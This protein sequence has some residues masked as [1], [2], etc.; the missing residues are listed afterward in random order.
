V[1]PHLTRINLLDAVVVGDRG[2]RG[3]LGRQRDHRYRM[4]LVD[5]PAD[6]L[7]AQMLGLR[8]AAAVAGHE[9]AGSAG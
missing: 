2:H 1:R 4:A 7:G 6:E 8:R 9:H 5:V 3:R